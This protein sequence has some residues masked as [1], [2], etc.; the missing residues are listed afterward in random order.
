MHDKEILQVLSN[1]YPYLSQL[2]K[3]EQVLADIRVAVEVLKTLTA[4]LKE[5]DSRLLEIMTALDEKTQEAIIDV[6]GL[7]EN[8]SAL[9]RDLDEW[10]LLTK[11][12]EKDK[13]D[14]ALDSVKKY[15]IYGFLISLLAFGYKAADKVFHLGLPDPIEIIEKNKG[16]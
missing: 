13:E 2:G 5:S 7:K 15:I 3:N 1:L 10:K 4:E 6:R 14:D 11:D 12:K 9:E 8:L 16:D